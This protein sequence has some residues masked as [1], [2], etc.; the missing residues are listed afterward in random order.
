VILSDI[1]V[2]RELYKNATYVQGQND[3]KSALYTAL[4]RGGIIPEPRGIYTWEKAAERTLL[5]FFRV[6]LHKDGK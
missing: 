4:H 5:F 2:H 1:A 6:L 3:L